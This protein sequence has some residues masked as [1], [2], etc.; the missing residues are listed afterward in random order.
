MTKQAYFLCPYEIQIVLRNQVSDYLTKY[1]ARSSLEHL[2]INCM[3]YSYQILKFD[4]YKDENWRH[5]K[6]SFKPNR[7]DQ[8]IESETVMEKLAN[9]VCE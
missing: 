8:Y 7:N 5:V 9:V 2:K 6:K 4:I 3:E 1:G